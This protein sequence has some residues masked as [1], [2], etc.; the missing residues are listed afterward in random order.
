MPTAPYV[1]LLHVNWSPEGGNV[2]LVVPMGDEAVRSEQEATL[3]N[4]PSAEPREFRCQ[5]LRAT[6]DIVAPNGLRVAVLELDSVDKQIELV[7]NRPSTHDVGALKV[8]LEPSNLIAGS[9]FIASPCRLVCIPTIGGGS[10]RNWDYTVFARFDGSALSVE[11]RQTSASLRNSNL[12]VAVS[13][14]EDGEELVM[15][16]PRQNFKVLATMDAPAASMELLGQFT[17]RD[18]R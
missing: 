3:P 9:K 13:Q 4:G 5:S 11:L 2:L 8:R 7:K 12:V 16:I 10:P 17:L 15:T 14:L 18:S 6:T 1:E